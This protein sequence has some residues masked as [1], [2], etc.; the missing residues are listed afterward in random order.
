MIRLRR[1]V[2]RTKSSRIPLHGG[3]TRSSCERNPLGPV[4]F[5]LLLLMAVSGIARAAS[6][7]SPAISSADMQFFENKVRPVLAENCYKCHSRDADKVKGGLMLDT[8]EGLLHGGST[9]PAIEP[10]NPDKSLLVQAIRYTDEDMQMPPKGNKLS[11][12]QIADLTEWV[13]RGAPDPRALA[14]KGSSAAYAG[15]GR[16]HWSFLPLKKPNV[17]AVENAAW[18]QSPIDNFI[19]EKLEASD[20][21]P[22]AP[23]DKRTLLRRVS[24]DLIGLPPSEDEVNA[25]LADTSPGAYAKVVDRLLASPQYGE[26]WGRYWLDVA[27]YADTKG[28]PPKREDPRFPHAWTYRDYVISAFNHDKPFNQFIIEQLAA[29]VLVVADMQ[30]AKTDPKKVDQSSL[31]A[32][33]FLTLGNQFEGNA[34]DII[35][36]RIDVTTKAFLGLTVS[37]ARCHDHKFDPIPTKDYYSLYGVFANTFAPQSAKDEP[38]VHPV[39][40][41]PELL[42]YMAKLDDLDKEKAQL[43]ADRAEYARSRTKDKAKNQEFQ[44]RETAFYREAGD[45]EASDAAPPRAYILRDLPQPKNYPVLVRG[46]AGNKGDVVPRHFLEILSGPKRP[47]YKDGSGRIDLARDIASPT[48]PLTARVLVNRLW[49]EHFGAGFVATPDDLGNMSSAPTHPEL[50]DYLASC[51]IEGGWSIKKIQRMIVLSSVY[52]ESGATNP[53]YADTDPDNK[54]LWRYNL[55]RLDFEEVHDSLLAIA[56]SLDLTMGGK[57]IPIGSGDFA[58]RRAVYTYIDRRNPAEI[59][60]QFDFPN[61]SVPTG[62]RYETIVPQQS[63][64]LMNSPLVIETA[65]KLT[66]RDD[67]L[68]LD[69]DDSRVASLY[70]AIFQRPPT[71]EETKLCLHYLE[72]NPG[73]ISTEARG[74]AG[75]KMGEGAGRAALRQAQQA[76]FAAKNPRG[77]NAPQIEPAAAAF[78]SRAPLDA[79][80]KLAHAL[81]QTNEAMFYN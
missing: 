29:D 34:N 72:K 8:R 26:R 44:K 30:K 48:N 47:D 31:A 66:H 15:V 19:L 62:R 14:A 76:E 32:L 57:S 56:G 61:P 24:F 59:L 43:A 49:Q 63:L 27:R 54:L 9:G 67:F 4:G 40:K 16:D 37:C 65:R 51:F 58:T 28:D 35:N 25:F 73:G 71:A 33:G 50:L 20:L 12:Q 74:P 81:F 39:P 13:R 64:F 38:T 36:D 2:N 79:W 70:L 6:P 68:Q 80:T 3:A 46:E 69:S 18:C 17:P 23:A 55:R 45:L 11:D 77:K 52:Q 75:A 60:T 41:T 78:K 5:G 1:Y 21:A 10:G 7:S 22:N 42:A 53:K